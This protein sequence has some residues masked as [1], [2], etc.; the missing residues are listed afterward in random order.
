MSPGVVGVGAAI[1]SDERARSYAHVRCV[2]RR[3]PAAPLW[4]TVCG[5]L[6]ALARAPASEPGVYTVVRVTLRTLLYCVVRIALFSVLRPRRSNWPRCRGAS[7]W[8]SSWI[9][10]P[11]DVPY[12]VCYWTRNSVGPMTVS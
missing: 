2:A 1:E 5:P 9:W 12:I 7:G 10:M 3:E 8:I 6:R 11:S 4:A